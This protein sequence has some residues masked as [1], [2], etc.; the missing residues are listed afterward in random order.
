[1]AIDHNQLKHI[2]EE[3]NALKGAQVQDVFTSGLN[4]FAL[5]VYLKGKTWSLVFDL[6]PA[7]PFVARLDSHGVKK[8]KNPW[9]V[10]DFLRSHF[11]GTRF[12][13]AGILPSPDRTVALKFQHADGD[14]EIS[15]QC[16]PHGQHLRM[17][18]HKKSF[19]FPPREEELP[20]FSWGLAEIP[21]GVDS[22][23]V[24]QFVA[25]QEFS[26]R[27]EAAQ[28][29]QTANKGAQA[30]GAGNAQLERL[31]K[32]KQKLERAI[33]GIQKSGEGKGNIDALKE[34]GDKLKSDPKKLKEAQ[35][36]LPK[37]I[38]G[39]QNLGAA[40]QSVFQAIKKEE[41]KVA[42]TAQRL[43]DLKNQLAQI[44]EQIELGPQEQA[45]DRN[46][47]DSD[48]NQDTLKI[49]S[50]HKRPHPFSG[51]R[52]L[53]REGWELW[54][55]RNASQNEELLKVA[56][57]NDTWIHLRDYPGAHGI[58]RGPSKKEVAPSDLEFSCCIVAHL[59]TSKKNPWVEGEKLDFYVVPRKF[60]K[61]Q[62]GQGAGKVIVER[63]T[64]RCVK[65]VP[66]KHFEILN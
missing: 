24:S 16:F 62:K 58:I 42:I 19:S 63:E 15:Y 5:I 4:Q 6:T 45:A 8:K 37:I 9:A 22:N 35:S 38:D 30:S 31:L 59:S 52:V 3:I 25:Q 17:W 50:T 53:I 27:K 39:R 33:E 56:S 54:V 49:P 34:W 32:Q 23:E 41:T 44:N 13:E 21:D 51:I 20:K 66:P 29:N 36:A 12:V 64:V 18:A 40:I 55:G 60:I 47:K 14:A 26:A 11:K 2:V 10:V 28:K 65:F 46:A 48:R 43:G 1:M 57:P 61:K 7:H